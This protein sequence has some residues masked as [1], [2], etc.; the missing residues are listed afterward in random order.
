M[1]GST[2]SLGLTNSDCQ[3][4]VDLRKYRNLGFSELLTLIL[5]EIPC[6]WYSRVALV[7]WMNFRSWPDEFRR[8]KL[9]I[10]KR[11]A[12]KIK[13]KIYLLSRS[14]LSRLPPKNS[15]P[16]LIYIYISLRWGP[17]APLSL[18]VHFSSEIIYF[19]SVSI[20]FIFNRHSFF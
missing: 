19:V 5:G 7:E 2:L 13:I 4:A 3:N 14:S 16:P 18:S 9:H 20:L 11:E 8:S 1:H 6:F 10:S 12:K 15:A 17:H